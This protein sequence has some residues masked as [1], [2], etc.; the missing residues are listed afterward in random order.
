M[1]QREFT[2]IGFILSLVILL[3]NDFYLKSHYGNWLTG[4]LSDFTGLFIF[5]LFWTILFPKLKD[6][7]YFVSAILFIYWKTVYSESLIEII[8]Q[9]SIISLNRVVDLTDLLALLILPFSYS[10]QKNSNKK[11]I[12][13]NPTFI[14]ALTSF[15]FIATSYNTK[16]EY[17]KT[18]S[19]NYPLDTLKTKIYYL[20]TIAN[21]Y[22]KEKENYILDSTRKYKIH[23]YF[24]D[25]IDAKKP[26]IDKFI[27]D[28]TDL[29]IFEDFCF[30]GYNAKLVISGDD[31]N[32]KIKVLGFHH[33]CPKN[34]KTLT[35]W[36]NDE[37]I[38]SE[39]F[40]KKVIDQIK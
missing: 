14:I 35:K 21:K 34:E 24:W 32:S 9:Y 33:S 20:K 8:N 17:Q 19:F 6:K 39:S 23:K 29:F 2:S 1:K 26:P 38:L 15:S 18:Y 16:I 4:K 36:N 27:K 12:S 28:T 3:L 30:E 22:E 13:I 25:T 37:E 10:Y 5:P 40:E 7:I 11:F 31:K